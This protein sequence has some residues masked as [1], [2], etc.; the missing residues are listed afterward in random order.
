MVA[1]H[2]LVASLVAAA[3]AT[4][5]LVREDA[6]FASLL[7][8]QE[9]GTPAYNCHDN[10]GSA[11]TLSRGADPCN[12]A[13]FVTDYNNCLKCSGP[14]NY[15]I[16]RYYGGTLSSAGEKC[17]L[18]TEPWAGKQD[19]VPEAGSTGTAS[20]AALAQTSAAAQTSIAPSAAASSAL[21]PSS[22]A[23][24]SSQSAATT[25]ATT[26]EAPVSSAAPLSAPESAVVTSAISS[27]PFYPTTVA[28]GTLSSS[29]SGAPTSS[30]NASA[31]ST[32]SAP[33]EVTTNAAAGVHVANTAGVFGA[34]FLGALFGSNDMIS[35]PLI[36]MLS[37]LA[38]A[39]AETVLGATVFSRHGDRTSKHYKG[40]NLTNLGFQQNYY[41]GQD[42]RNIY[43]N[44]SSPKQILDISEDQVVNSQ[45]YA[46]APDQAVLLNTATAFL[47]GLY[48][49]TESIDQV[50]ATQ[51]LNSDERVIRPLGGYQ[52][53]VI[54]GEND[55]SP[56]AIYLKG[57][58]EC[59]A[60]TTSTK[61]YKESAAFKQRIEQTRSFYESF[62][63]QL[64]SVY[65][66]HQANLSFANAYDIFDLLNVASI[67]NATHNGTVSSDDLSQLRTLAD[68]WESHMAYDTA[69]SARSIGGQTFAGGVLEQLDQIVTT[70]GKLKFALLAGSYDTFLAFFGLSKLIAVSDN[71]SGLPD[72]A[73]TMAFEVF[74]PD[75][76]IAFPSVAD[77][78]V[79]FMFRN[80]STEGEAPTVYPLFGG[81]E[82]SLPYN[83]F[84]SKMKEFAITSPE[85]WCSTCR[86]DA[87]FCQAYSARDTA[88]NSGRTH[89]VMSNT[90]AGAIGALVTLEAVAYPDQVK[91]RFIDEPER[92]KRLLKVFSDYYANTVPDAPYEARVSKAKVDVRDILQG[93]DDLVEGFDSFVPKDFESKE[94][95]AK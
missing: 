79:R 13:V 50:S 77:L 74:T 94:R 65:D 43:L 37:L 76:V 40:Y 24:A 1:A 39:Q 21:A 25:E 33:A 28:N 70:K 86:S 52:Y 5:L 26:S 10:C 4:D 88:S 62:W 15:N 8:R 63:D 6:Y 72:Y 45:I 36:A 44:S 16:W 61:Q 56:D 78:R 48:P 35:K 83:D 17:G 11:I 90:I 31:S 27:A 69:D 22:A 93:H 42:Y 3:S 47:Q 23:A 91:D 87:L 60:V 80:G 29:V 51:T 92:Y 54:H 57:D 49:P 58:E 71:F 38:P 7:K 75:D 34:I 89:S 59:P 85:Q 18:D 82:Q 73:S 46:S 32:A 84:V 30:T 2:F 9:P 64:S 66:Y 53:P 12:N 19:D 68:E 41:V 95:E 20:S 67:H 14:D 55:D 81:Q